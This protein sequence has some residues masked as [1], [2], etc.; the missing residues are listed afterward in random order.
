MMCINR[1]IHYVRYDYD[2]RKDNDDFTK[3]KF[4]KINVSV[5]VPFRATTPIKTHK[6]RDESILFFLIVYAQLVSFYPDRFDPVTRY[7]R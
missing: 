2:G 6:I 7:L 4:C 1:M 3:S 5:N